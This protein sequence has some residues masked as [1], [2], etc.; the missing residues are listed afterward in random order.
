MIQTKLKICTGGC[1]KPKPIW[2]NHEG[3]R[4]CKDCWSDLNLKIS[5]GKAVKKHYVI[6][7]RSE[8][9]IKK[10]AAYYV[11]QKKY[12]A[13]HP[14]CELNIE[15]ECTHKSSEIHHTYWGKDRDK[16][17]NDF[18]TVKAGCTPCHRYVHDKMSAEE[19]IEKGFKRV[20][21]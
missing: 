5:G 11:L 20:D 2:K 9:R 8:K 17:M 14:V 1:H 6:P 7:K 21:N 10:D 19:A 12:L 16:Y 4:Y 13:D 15:G 18:T 3:K